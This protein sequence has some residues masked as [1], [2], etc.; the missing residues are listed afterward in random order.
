MTKS[1]TANNDGQ[2][3][4]DDRK[5]SLLENSEMKATNDEA[6]VP[7]VV[8]EAGNFSGIDPN[9]IKIEA[10]ESSRASHEGGDPSQMHQQQTD[11]PNQMFKV[12]IQS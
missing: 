3:Q 9:F 5:N 11:D 2:W 7:E 1:K 4:L 6:V 8:I 12:A 10:L